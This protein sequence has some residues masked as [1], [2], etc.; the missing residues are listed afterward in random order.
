MFIKEKYSKSVKFNNLTGSIVFF[1]NKKFEIKNIGNLLNY[2]HN[3]LFKKSLKNNTKKKEIFSFD[4]N[5][6]QKIIV[7]S[8]KYKNNSY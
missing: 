8:P 5:H 2:S 6:N 1:A 4:I 3:N 7:Y